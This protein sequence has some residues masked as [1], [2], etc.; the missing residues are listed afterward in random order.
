MAHSPL[1][2]GTAMNLDLTT[3]T[4]PLPKQQRNPRRT[5]LGIAALALTVAAGIAAW[6]VTGQRTVTPSQPATASTLE[7]TGPSTTGYPTNTSI[8]YI[9]RSQDDADLV[10]RIAGEIGGS[11][12]Y[13]N[14]H[15]AA[16]DVL[17]TAEDAVTVAAVLPR[18]ADSAIVD[19]R[20]P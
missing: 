7:S 13:P 9:V 12:T 15:P 4:T 5:V 3:T 11:Q 8:I 14:R 2:K 19:L 1:T 16:L 17:V 10:Q 6:Q 18:A 20:A